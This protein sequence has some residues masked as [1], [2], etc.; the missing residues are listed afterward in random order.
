MDHLDVTPET[1]A[2]VLK[3]AKPGDTLALAAGEYRGVKLAGVSGLTITAQDPQDS[4]RILGGLNIRAAVELRFS[5]VRFELGAVETTSAGVVTVTGGSGVAFSD[6]DFVGHERDDGARFGRGLVASGVEELEVV[7]NRFTRLFRGAVI[8]GSVDVAVEGNDLADLGSDGLNLGQVAR[9]RVVGNQFVGF[10]PKAGDHPDGIQI[11]TTAAG[12]ASEDVLIEGNLVVC[13]VT[14]R[15]QGIFVKA[16]NPAVRHRN[17]RVVDN[18]LCNAGYNAISVGSTDDAVITGNTCLFMP[19]PDAK[20]SWIRT[21]GTAGQM[22]GNAAMGYI[23]P[24]GM[25]RSDDRTI[26]A[27]TAGQIAEAIAEW[28]TKWRPEPVASTLEPEVIE[29][30]LKPGQRLIVTGAA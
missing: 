21:E 29:I 25:S 4:P 12:A 11:M 1:F 6:C 14:G 8:A 30:A 17:I 16:E 23:A 19:T 3:T 13:G 20:S 15:A 22:S 10:K 24:E 5:Q 28:R 27:A 7:G 2:T 26:P 18:V 9:A